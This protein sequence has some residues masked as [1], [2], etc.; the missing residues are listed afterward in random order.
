[1]FPLIKNISLHLF[2]NKILNL[3]TC[4][5]DPKSYKTYVTLNIPIRV[6]LC[7]ALNVVPQVSDLC[8]QPP[9]ATATCVGKRGSPKVATLM[10]KCLKFT[11]YLCYVKIIHHILTLTWIF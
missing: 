2:F 5:S 7:A 8:A 6:L 1:M 4:Q 10:E 11:K 9:T 3:H